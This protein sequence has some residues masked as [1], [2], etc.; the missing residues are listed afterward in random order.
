LWDTFGELSQA[1]R[2]A[3]AAFVGGSLAPLGGQ[4]FLEPLISGIRP[5]IG[6]YWETFQW[7]G[8][9][10][11]DLGLVRVVADWKEAADTL[12]RDVAQPA[13]AEDV[14][15]E[16]RRYIAARQGGTAAAWALIREYLQKKSARRLH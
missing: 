15:R 12:A 16:A 14:R 2:L 3:T 7:V 11:M 8:Q 5:V 4:N 1:Y 9:D 6:P 13:A 10:I